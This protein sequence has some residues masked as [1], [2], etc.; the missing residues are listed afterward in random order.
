MSVCWVG[1]C[2]MGMIMEHVQLCMHASMYAS[3][4]QRMRVR[5]F[6]H[7]TKSN[8]VLCGYSMRV[9]ILALQVQLVHGERGILTL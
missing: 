2:L 1:L 5:A 6:A 9:E 4:H 7:I 3:K 8:N